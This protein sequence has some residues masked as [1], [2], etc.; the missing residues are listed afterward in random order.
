MV[1]EGVGGVGEISTARPADVAASTFL[2][3]LNDG[4]RRLFVM[5]LVL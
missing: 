3:G 1:G 4:S 2:I 5:V